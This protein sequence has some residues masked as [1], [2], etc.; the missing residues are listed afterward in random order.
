MN[1]MA[2]ETVENDAVL[3]ESLVTKKKKQSSGT[4]REKNRRT[5][6]PPKL[7]RKLRQTKK[8]IGGKSWVEGKKVA[9]REQ[10]N[11]GSGKA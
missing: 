11:L 1:W 8:K 2:G 10:K 7:A 4:G 5:G 3:S 6:L 9:R